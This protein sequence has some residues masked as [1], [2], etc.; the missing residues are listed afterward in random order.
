MQ[1]AGQADFHDAKFMDE[2]VRLLE[3]EY[4]I[5]CIRPRCTIG[6]HRFE[7]YNFFINAYASFFCFLPVYWLGGEFVKYCTS[8]SSS[9]VAAALLV[10]V[11]LFVLFI[12]SLPGLYFLFLRY[13]VILFVLRHTYYYITN[14]RF[15]EVFTRFG[16]LIYYI[17]FSDIA[18]LDLLE[19]GSGM[20]SHYF[21]TNESTPLPTLSRYLY[22]ANSVRPILP[23]GYHIPP[24]TLLNI[25]ADIDIFEYI[26]KTAS[27]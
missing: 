19:N 4:V 18:Y 17:K 24:I 8:L 23:L 26:K 25:D 7:I 6:W 2:P 5:R 1:N 11:C 10:I 12:I 16:G 9:S 15:I 27:A 22:S 13:F 3:N 21:Y 20:N 14:Q